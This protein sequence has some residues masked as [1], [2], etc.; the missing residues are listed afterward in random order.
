MLFCPRSANGAGQMVDITVSIE[1]LILGL[2]VS[3]TMLTVGLLGDV[4]NARE[5]YSAQADEIDVS[6]I[7][8]DI[9]LESWAPK[10]VAA[11]PIEQLV[12]VE[13]LGQVRTTA[14]KLNHRSCA[15]SDC[16]ISGSSPYGSVLDYYEESGNWLRVSPADAAREEWVSREYAFSLVTPE[17]GARKA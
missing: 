8:L 14:T 11:A 7:S 3:L 12:V 13:A 2:F 9:D 16:A 6:L 15:S 10:R 17:R 1:R 5:H 4:S